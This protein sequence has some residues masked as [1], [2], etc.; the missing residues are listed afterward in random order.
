MRC[1]RAR[2]DAVLPLSKPVRGTDGELLHSI[3]VPKGT[4]I[5]VLIQASN[6]SPELWGADAHEWR[7]ERWLE[8]LPD[9]LAGAK[10][11]GVYSNLCVSS[12]IWL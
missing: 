11:P 9:A 2:A 7:P 8:P 5:F 12:L 6:V 1:D 3:F 10:I 4:R